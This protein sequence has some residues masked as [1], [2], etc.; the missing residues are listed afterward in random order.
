[1]HD[2]DVYRPTKTADPKKIGR[3]TF[4]N[5]KAE[6]KVAVKTANNFFINT[7]LKNDTVVAAEYNG[8][9]IHQDSV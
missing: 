7:K 6:E 8:P 9:V 1:M 4:K 2:S 5:N 3:V